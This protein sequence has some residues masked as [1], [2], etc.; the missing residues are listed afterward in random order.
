MTAG[1]KNVVLVV[2]NMALSDCIIHAGG[3]AYNGIGMKCVV[4]R[5]KKDSSDMR[6]PRN[7][8]SER[9]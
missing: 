4:V 7:D 1:S 8:S 2:L 6:H 3:R 5:K 9:F